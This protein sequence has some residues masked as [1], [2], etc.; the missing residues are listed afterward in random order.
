MDNEQRTLNSSDHG[1]EKVDQSADVYTKAASRIESSIRVDASPDATKAN[2][3]F[4]ETTRYVGISAGG[5]TPLGGG[6]VAG[7]VYLD[8]HG[9]PGAYGSAGPNVGAGLPD[10]SVSVVWGESSSFSGQSVNVS[11]S[12]SVPIPRTAIAVEISRGKSFDQDTGSLTGS[13]TSIGIGPS[14]K[15][16]PP[17][18]CSV[19]DTYTS[20]SEFTSLYQTY[21][22]FLNHVGY[23]SI[24]G[25]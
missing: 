17:I 21:I 22:Q 24:G 4:V 16:S 6:E 9:F 12:I 2:H 3:D 5:I 20:T 18:S 8:R 14:L 19:S 13:F 7:G 1:S 15:N 11:C 25:M 10:A 23:P